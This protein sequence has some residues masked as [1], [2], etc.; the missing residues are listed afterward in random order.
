M[1]TA[2]K[3]SKLQLLILLVLNYFTFMLITNIIGVLFVNW[4]ADFRLKPEVSKFLGAAFFIAYGLT[5]LPN[6][7]L[8]ERIGSKNTFLYAVALIFIG[9]LIFAMFPSFY[10]GLFSLFITG[11]GVTALQIVGNL[12]VK[13]VDDDPEKYSRNLTMAQVFCGLGGMSGGLLNSWMSSTFENYNWTIFYYI[14]AGLILAL[15]ILA[16]FTPMPDSEEKKES[17]GWGDYIKLL[18]NPTMLMFALGIFIY[19]GIEVGIANWI[20]NYLKGNLAYN[21]GD[22]GIIFSFYWGAQA[23]GRFT[24]GFVLN[25]LDNSK[26]LI[27]YA[28]SALTSLLV[29]VFTKS[30]AIAGMAFIAV[31][32]FTSVMFPV[33]FSLAVNTFDDKKESVAGILCTAIIGGSVIQL[34]IG[35]FANIISLNMS[36][37]IIST[38][39]FLYIAY[40]GFNTV[41]AKK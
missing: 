7:L 39:C 17:P 37:A 13:K 26:A 15:G 23:I 30:P 8:L 40:I 33:I 24:S 20:V 32:F 36:L 11:A 19:V 25:Y 16:F 3:S 4:E 29:A 38:I 28:I 41:K 21:A 31:G 1:N 9:S 22:A 2:V 10:T 18:I 5:S 35:Y 12:L 34:L 6:G 27:L 14:F